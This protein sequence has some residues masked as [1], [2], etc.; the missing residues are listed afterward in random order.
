MPK[1]P[2]DLAKL[3]ITINPRAVSLS[4][5]IRA[6]LSVAALIALSEYLH[7]PLLREAALAA[8]LAC[9]SDV[10][11]PIH[12]RVPVLVGFTVMGAATVFVV[13]LLR[14]LGPAV[15]LPL[16]VFG[17]FC[18]SFGRIY[19]QATQQVGAV[20]TSVLIL[21]LDRGEPSLHSAALLATAFIG[22]GL[23]AALLTLVIWRVYPFLPARRAVAE[24]DRALADLVG[25]LYL[26]S[27]NPSVTEADWEAHARVH[28]GRT[29]EALEAARAAILSTLKA[30]GAA[31][32][33]AAQSVIRLETADQVF[34]ALI[35]LS[36]LLEHASMADRHTVRRI[37]R[38]MR[39]ML[40]ELARLVRDEDEAAH[41]RIG[42]A[43]E[44]MAADQWRLPPASPLRGVTESLIERLRIAYTIAVPANIQPGAD[45]EGRGPPLRE[46]LLAPLRTNLTWQSPAL[47][48]ALRTAVTAAPA[49]AFT[50]AWFTPY[51]HWLTITIVATMQPYFSLTY[52]RAVE[53]IGGTAL[54][55]VIAAAVGLVC[56]T[57]LSMAAGMFVLSIVGFAIRSVSFGLFMMGLTPMVVLLVETGAPETHEWTIA[58]ARAG[59]TA[60]GGIIAVG[61][62]FV[63]W[64]SWDPELIAPQ[65]K[66]ALAAHAD[67]AEADFGSLLGEVD[68]PALDAARRAAGLS[69]NALEA[70]ITRALLN[71]GR[72]DTE[73]LEAAMAIDAA[74]RRCAGRLA[75][76]QHDPAVAGCMTPEALRTWRHWIGSSLRLLAEGRTGL[77]PRPETTNDT[78]ARITRQ[79]ELM[80]G[81]LRRLA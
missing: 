48:H 34:G 32:S 19:G 50:M 15:A 6:G 70:L 41:S 8:L 16:G 67:Y 4:E 49:L 33:R 21:S 11:G 53:R 20:L 24:A 52:T 12:R 31:S 1:R 29:R 38:R 7:S 46:A 60:L 76:L 17:I 35:S 36:D 2:P 25:D 27:G 26:L 14:N 81:A 30:R 64:P 3:P 43:I 77:P 42:R 66:A 37:L 28:R 56:T 65:V 51:D 74:L 57:P 5:G 79:I 55:G 73:A 68:P 18:A 40:L 54:G 71:F 59:L 80:E 45:R 10:S 44:H 61:A 22:G 63:L 72:Q 9:I 13:G 75:T 58:A 47:R 62:N 23:W 69:S 39:P 78:L